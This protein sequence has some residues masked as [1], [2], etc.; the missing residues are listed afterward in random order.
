[1]HVD[2]VDPPGL[3]REN[4]S[5]PSDVDV[6]LDLHGA[7]RLFEPVLRSQRPSSWHPLPLLPLVLLIV[8]VILLGGY[9]SH[10]LADVD[11]DSPVVL[12]L[13]PPSYFHRNIERLGEEFGVEGLED[14]RDVEPPTPAAALLTLLAALPTGASGEEERLFSFQRSAKC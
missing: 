5:F 12:L 1:M 7:E 11:H 4:V 2:D 3:P 10:P 6:L 8:L 9:H 13:Q 14:V